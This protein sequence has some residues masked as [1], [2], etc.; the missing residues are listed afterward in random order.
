MF[1]HPVHLSTQTHIVRSASSPC[2]M[3][4]GTTLPTFPAQSVGPPPHRGN[5]GT[6]LGTG[7]AIRADATAQ[8][9]T[10]PENLHSYSGTWDIQCDIQSYTLL[11]IGRPCARDIGTAMSDMPVGKLGSQMRLQ[12]DPCSSHGPS[13]GFTP[14]SVTI[15]LPFTSDT[16]FSPSS[17]YTCSTQVQYCIAAGQFD[18]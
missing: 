12:T 15:A 17:C 1:Y 9:P 3:C 18:F 6:G 8:V 5:S 10:S 13:H 2:T 14:A 4:M 7:C 16:Q 11:A